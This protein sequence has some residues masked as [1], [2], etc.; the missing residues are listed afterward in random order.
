M[1]GPVTTDQ[2]APPWGSCGRGCRAATCVIILVVAAAA[3]S[4]SSSFLRLFYVL[5]WEKATTSGD[6]MIL[7]AGSEGGN[8]GCRIFLLGAT[9]VFP[10]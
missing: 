1:A 6:C 10:G 9:V 8:D 2:R 4:S 3:A 5:H 7:L